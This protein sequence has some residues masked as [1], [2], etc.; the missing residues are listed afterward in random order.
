MGKG[1]M[2]SSELKRSIEKNA[3]IRHRH[4]KRAALGHILPESGTFDDEFVR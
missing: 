4:T 2:K 3:I 1:D